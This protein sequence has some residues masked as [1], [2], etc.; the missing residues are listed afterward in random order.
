MRSRET[1]T[2]PEELFPWTQFVSAQN[3][4]GIGKKREGLFDT[5]IVNQEIDGNKCNTRKSHLNIILQNNI[6]HDSNM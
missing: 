5:G 2:S 3:M 6:K 4:T 1:I